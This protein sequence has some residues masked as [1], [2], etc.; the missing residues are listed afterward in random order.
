MLAGQKARLEWLHD[1]DL[2]DAALQPEA[3]HRAA[4][5]SLVAVLEAHSCGCLIFAARR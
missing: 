1:L 4:A 5:V 3:K 2:L